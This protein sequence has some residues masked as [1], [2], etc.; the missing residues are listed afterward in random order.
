MAERDKTAALS[1]NEAANM[2]QNKK[3]TATEFATETD[4][5]IARQ[6]NQMFPMPGKRSKE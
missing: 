5:S 1:V 2:V 3:T 6:Q 4:A